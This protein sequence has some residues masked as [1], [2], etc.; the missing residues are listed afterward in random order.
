MMVADKLPNLEV[1]LLGHDT[2]IPRA[3]VVDLSSD[4]LTTE[5]R[6]FYDSGAVSYGARLV[7]QLPARLRER[8]SLLPSRPQAELRDTYR[9][10]DFLV[11]PSVWNEPFGMIAAEAM[12][13]GLPVIVSRG[14][15]TPELVK[16]EESGLL[17]VAHG[18]ASGL[19]KPEDW[20]MPVGA[21]RWCHSHSHT[22]WS[23]H[24]LEGKNAFSRRPM[25]D[26]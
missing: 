23:H 3:F 5:L 16:H 8:V 18:G 24:C 11:F 25:Q 14:G 2:F 20:R 1:S 12:S 10:F 13:C 7:S 9:A 6:R 19:P 26:F 21:S 22:R 15:G 4:P 17:V